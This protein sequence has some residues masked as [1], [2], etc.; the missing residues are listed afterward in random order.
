[1]NDA[2]PTVLYI[3]DND[4]NIQ[5]VKGVLRRRPEVRLLTATHGGAGIELAQAEL[6]SL[7]LLDL[8]LPDMHGAEVLRE[9]REDTRTCDIPVVVISA[10]AT[11]AQIS[12]L[13]ASGADHYIS[14]PF[15]VRHLLAVIDDALLRADRGDGSTAA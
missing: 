3:E 1:V 12:R 13:G 5:L 8:H 11:A 15:E 14:K 7:V 2:P 10:D 6:P 9:L 4:S